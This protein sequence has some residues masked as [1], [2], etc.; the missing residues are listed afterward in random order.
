MHVFQL[1]QQSQDVSR[2]HN[3]SDIDKKVDSRGVY[4]LPTPIPRPHSHFV[5]GL[6][7][8]GPLL[9]RFQGVSPHLSHL[10]GDAEPGLG[11]CRLRPSQSA[12]WWLVQT[13]P[14]LCWGHQP[15]LL[16]PL[17]LW[18]LV[19]LHL[20]SRENSSCTRETVEGTCM[21]SGSKIKDHFRLW[22]PGTW[23]RTD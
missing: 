1:S 20:C 17:Q 21:R 13:S 22:K 6:C 16:S 11:C 12:G 10:P 8:S 15:L 18:G 4:W 3:V 14:R 19:L 23:A 2:A 7:T 5:S 9:Q